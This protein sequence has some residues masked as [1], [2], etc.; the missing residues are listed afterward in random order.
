V[1]AKP[2]QGEITCPHYQQTPGSKRCRS[3]A[4]GGACQ[5]PDAAQGKCLEWLKVNAAREPAPEPAPRDLFGAPV[6][7]PPPRQRPHTTPLAPTTAPEPGPP[8]VRNVTDEQISSFKA[9]G[10]EVCIQSAALGP[11]WLVPMYTGAEDRAELSIDHAVTLT[12]ICSAFPGAKV[13][14]MKRR[15]A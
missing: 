2:N 11:V 14:E 6:R 10:V 4:P 7:P 15:S 5:R 8:L 12:T 9:L 1:P 3:Y 13:I